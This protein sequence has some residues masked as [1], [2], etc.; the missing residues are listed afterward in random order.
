[1]KKL[2]TEQLDMFRNFLIQKKKK[3]KEKNKN[4]MED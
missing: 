2:K 3:K 4:I 1:M